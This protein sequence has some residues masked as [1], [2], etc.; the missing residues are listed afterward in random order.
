MAKNTEPILDES[1]NRHVI[2]PIKY[3]NIWQMYK[4]AVSSFWTVE[5]IAFTDIEDWH[6]LTKN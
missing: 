6:K 5:E 2:F 4:K 3:N 1:N